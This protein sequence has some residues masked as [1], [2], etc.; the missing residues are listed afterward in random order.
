MRQKTE[1][2]GKER[3]C[4]LLCAPI[5]RLSGLSLQSA[6]TIARR[7]QYPERR[8]GMTDARPGQLALRSQS[9]SRLLSSLVPAAVTPEYLAPNSVWLF[10]WQ[11]GKEPERDALQRRFPEERDSECPREEVQDT[12]P[13]CGKCSKAGDRCWQ[14]SSYSRGRHAGENRQGRWRACCSCASRAHGLGSFEAWAKK[15]GQNSHSDTAIR[16]HGANPCA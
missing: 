13:D 5:Q 12:H 7:P 11:S 15:F 3:A 2:T 8:I 9:Q 6:V 4:Q 1:K 14:K 10:R 16:T